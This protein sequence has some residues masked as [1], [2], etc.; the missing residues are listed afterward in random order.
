MTPAR[1]GAL[2][3]G[4]PL[5]AVGVL[6]AAAVAVQILLLRLFAIIQWHHF[7]YL[8]I[9]LALL[10]YGAAGTFVTLTQDRLAQRAGR[11]IAVAMAGFG[12]VCVPAFALAQLVSFNPEE[13]LW[14]PI[15]AGRLAALY[16]LL[17]LPFFCAAT[18][19]ALIFRTW[20]AEA[21]RIYAADLVGAGAGGLASLGL[22]SWLAPLTAVALAG[23]AA[24]AAAVLAAARLGVAA[25]TRIAFAAGGAVLFVAAAAGLVEPRPSAYKDLSQAL[26]ADGARAELERPGP[27][28][29]LTVV[30]S[31][32]VPPRIAPGLSLLAPGGPPMQKLAFINGDLAG[33]ITRATPGG[34]EFT[35]WLPTAFPYRLR[36]VKRVLVADAGT[37]LDVMQ[38][39]ALGNDEPEELQVDA[40][41]ARRHLLQ[42][43]AEDY[44]DWTGDLYGR[45]GVRVI[46]TSPRAHLARAPRRYDLIVLP[47]AGA[48]GGA[49]LK[50][51]S[52]D[53]LRTQQQVTRM[54]GRLQPGGMLAA[55]CWVDLPVRSCLR[56]AATLIAGLEASGVRDPAGHLLAVRAWQLAVVVVSP[57]P[58]PASAADH[59]KAF[60]AARA[61]DPVWYPGMLRVEANRINRMAEPF[62]YDGIA[63]LTG[64]DRDA[65]L[66]NYAF[67]IRPVTEDRPFATSFLKLSSA[68][69]LRRLAASGAL[70]LVDAGPVLV[71]VALLQSLLIGV[72]LV[73]LPLSAARWRGRKALGG[74]GAAYFA[75]I[76]VAFMLLEIALLHR[77][78]LLLADPVRSAAV[79]IA[80]LLVAAGAGSA[81]TRALGARFGSLV[82]IRGAVAGIVALGLSLLVV[83][84]PVADAAAGWPLAGRV[85]LSLLLTAPIA[86]L[87]GMLLPGGLARLARDRA[88]ALPWAWAANGC[89]SV[90]GAVLATLLTLAFGFTACVLVALGLY[91][92]AAL[93]P[94]PE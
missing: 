53:P 6:S 91:G 3:H 19:I 47:P 52:E 56:L 64:P 9:S 2:G 81:A 12:L 48:L 34:A 46:A 32:Q 88:D 4:P 51:L 85:V 90:T 24:L 82:T 75:A 54:L 74:R 17:S 8:V 42:A 22:L 21:G 5:A 89:A 18:A 26:L 55:S 72:S 15:L 83:I 68:G 28:G 33:P 84:T 60:A 50:A 87:M 31:P 59:L 30:D 38:A 10:G 61:F 86:V 62:L 65:F 27:L 36:Q 93:V 67:D 23:M 70:A 49:G 73:L 44:R 20:P 41:D 76:G 57:E 13:L 69:E 29:T 45:P 40:V 63:A 58:W 7:A 80:G 94:P 79:V 71:A 92:V 16:I 35:D 78:S 11:H 43:V 25:P 1:G 39:F 14:R 66:E 37:G 77:L